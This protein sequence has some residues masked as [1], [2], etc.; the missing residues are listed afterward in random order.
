M[1]RRALPDWERVKQEFM[2]CTDPLDA[3]AERNGIG[4]GALTRHAKAANWQRKVTTVQRPRR[5]K[6]ELA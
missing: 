4:R 3:I 6:A 1:S 2:V 5:T